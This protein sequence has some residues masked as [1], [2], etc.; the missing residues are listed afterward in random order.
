MSR[1]G[2]GASGA[3]RD[4]AGSLTMPPPATGA[5]ATSAE[6]NAENEV[7]RCGGNAV[8]MEARLCEMISSIRAL[9]RSNVDLE[10]ALRESP[11][12]PDFLQAV[13]E[14]KLAIRRQGLVAQALVQEM[15]ALGAKVDLEGDVLDAISNVQKYVSGE[16]STAE[17]GEG[18]ASTDTSGGLYL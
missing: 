6:K 9:V 3:A 1:I 7:R 18:V 12:D 10:E 14:N 13:S 17:G 2:R 15:R 4:Q 8:L 11:E 16:R 5:A